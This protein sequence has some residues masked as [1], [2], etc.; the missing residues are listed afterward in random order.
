MN[1]STSPSHHML[2]APLPPFFERIRE[3][4]DTT[5]YAG[6]TEGWLLPAAQYHAHKGF[7]E[8]LWVPSLADTMLGVRLQGAHVAKC[9]GNG[10]GRSIPGRDVSLMPRGTPSAFRA[11]AEILFG[12]LPLPDALLDQVSER[13]QRPALSKRLRDDLVFVADPTLQDHAQTYLARAFDTTVVPT[14]LEMEARALLLVDQLHRLHDVQA[15]RDPAPGGLAAWQ[16]NRVC[17][18]LL[19]HLALDIGLST[20]ADLV[21]LSPKHFARAFKQSTGVPPH[22]W[23]IARRIERAQAL[24]HSTRL[25]LSEVA[26]NCGFADQ[27]HFTAT[28]RRVT[29]NSPGRYRAGIAS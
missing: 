26:L 22:Q 13:L 21:G 15:W 28:F 7:G 12:F 23:L 14:Q 11:E 16:L 25:T 3:A 18:F 5:R 17:D 1:T 20:L 2:Q 6:K 9:L 27:S 10:R 19:A 8:E 29:G 24:L 4:V